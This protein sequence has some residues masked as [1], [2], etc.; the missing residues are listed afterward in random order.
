MDYNRS[1]NIVENFLIYKLYLNLNT[2]NES[3]IE[4]PICISKIFTK[5]Y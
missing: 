4:I 2:E 1:R 5:Y 3:K